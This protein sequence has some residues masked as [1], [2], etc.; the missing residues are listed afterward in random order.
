MFPTR[1]ILSNTLAQFNLNTDW[2]TK[3]L[4]EVALD[5]PAVNLGVNRAA[6]VNLL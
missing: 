5:L 3:C 2:K 1:L 4:K 6:A